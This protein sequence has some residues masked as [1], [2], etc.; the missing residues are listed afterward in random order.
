MTL[1]PAYR[2]FP[3]VFA[4]NPEQL[5]I[6]WSQEDAMRKLEWQL[7]QSVPPRWV[8]KVSD[9][10]NETIDR[11]LDVFQNP[12][13]TQHKRGGNRYRNMVNAPKY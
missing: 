6:P 11:T 4:N 3:E 1:F 9:Y 10:Q 12:I 2:S 7:E 8:G 13:E 5:Y